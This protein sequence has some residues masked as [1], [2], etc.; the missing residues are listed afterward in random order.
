MIFLFSLFLIRLLTVFM[1]FHKAIIIMIITPRLK[2]KAISVALL[3]SGSL[4]IISLSVSL[5]RGI[6]SL[7]S[8]ICHTFQP[9]SPSSLALAH[10]SSSLH[11]CLP[12]LPLSIPVSY[13][14]SFPPHLPTPARLSFSPSITL[15]HKWTVKIPSEY[16]SERALIS[17]E[18]RMN[19]RWPPLS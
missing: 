8:F 1:T 6:G 17:N 11:V 19:K 2:L 9:L 3:L 5:F 12:S 14:L 4:G 13:L 16:R 18:Q 7:Q 10:H 15:S